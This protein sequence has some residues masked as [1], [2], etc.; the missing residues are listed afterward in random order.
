MFYTITP[1]H[2]VSYPHC[3]GEKTKALIQTQA[4]FS[5]ANFFSPTYTVAHSDTHKKYV[6]AYP[7]GLAVRDSA[8]SLLWLGLL[9]WLGFDLWPRKFL[10][11]TGTAQKKEKIYFACKSKLCSAYL[12]LASSDM[13]I[14]NTNLKPLS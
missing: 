4:I 13:Y 3:I 6:V 8:L 1:R 10:H 11:A 9:L 2:I 14:E 7:G 5:G 12:I